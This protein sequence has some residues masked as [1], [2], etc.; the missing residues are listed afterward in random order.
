LLETDF[1]RVRAALLRFAPAGFF[2]CFYPII[3]CPPVIR[4]TDSMLRRRIPAPF[5]TPAP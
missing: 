3:T 5:P 1:S 2:F 4:A